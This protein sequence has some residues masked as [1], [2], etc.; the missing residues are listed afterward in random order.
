MELIYEVTMDAEVDD[1][2]PTP[3]GFR[4]IV[5]GGRFSGP[6][7]RG[8]VQPGGGDWLVERR[9]GTRILD[10]RITL[11]TDDG[12]LIYA[13]YP[14]LFHA[15]PTVMDRLARGEMVDT[16]EYSFRTAPLFEAPATRGPRNAGSCCGPSFIP[17]DGRRVP[18]QF[19]GRARRASRR[20]RESPHVIRSHIG[21]RWGV[22]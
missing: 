12:H 8:T 1:V 10:V 2:G 9:D 17:S 6:K 18:G 15:A 19:E 22:W 14:G 7:L 3:L 11:K 13:H 20:G 16:S 21:R 5:T 4:R